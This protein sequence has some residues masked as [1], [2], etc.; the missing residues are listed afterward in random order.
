MPTKTEPDLSLC[1]SHHPFLRPQ[2]LEDEANKLLE[3]S[4]RFLFTSNRPDVVSAIIN[5]LSFLVKIR[6]SL[7]N[8]IVTSFTNWSTDGLLGQTATQ[9]RGVEKTLRI[10]LAHIFR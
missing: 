5:A 9:I 6:S 3:Q 1:P 10:A 4:I 8:L 2:S 7:A